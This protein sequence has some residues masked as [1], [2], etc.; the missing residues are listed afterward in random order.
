MKIG[1]KVTVIWNDHNQ[2]DCYGTPT[3]TITDYDPSTHL[4]TVEHHEHDGTKSR[5]YYTAD[6]ISTSPFLRAVSKAQQ[7]KI[8]R[9]L[10]V[11]NN[12]NMKHIKKVLCVCVL[13]VYNFVYRLAHF[14]RR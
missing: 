3:G 2:R 6:E 4:Y 12:M 11:T 7:N 1:K 5:G 8:E 9:I 14:L 13:S 10:N